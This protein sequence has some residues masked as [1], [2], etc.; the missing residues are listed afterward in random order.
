MP[1]KLPSVADRAIAAKAESRCLDFKERFDPKEQ[2]GWVELIKDF[3]A[4]ANSGG[5]LILVGV[6]NNGLPATGDVQPVLDLDP[7]TITDKVERYTRVHFDD[8]EISEVTR[9]GSRVAVIAVGASLEAPIA[10]TRPG[11]YPDPA[12]PKYQKTAFGMGTVYFRHGAKSE[13]GNTADLRRF[14]DR[15]VEQVREQWKAGMRLV[16]EAPEGARLAVVQATGTDP[17]AIPTR[18]RLTNDPAAPVYGQLSPDQTHPFRQSQLLP[19]L[20]KRLS[21]GSAVNPYDLLAVRRVLGIDATTRPD[22]VYQ[23]RWPNSSPQY[24][25]EFVDW[26]AEQARADPQFFEKARARFHATPKLKPA[27]K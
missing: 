4:M 27:K 24:S 8:F 13:P 26:L 1:R 17:A 15:R 9:N 25:E 11:T 3:V 14:I 20:N 5:G 22:F 12:S 23:P 10:F 21:P 16:T 7:A 2:S 19:E 6:R 18:F